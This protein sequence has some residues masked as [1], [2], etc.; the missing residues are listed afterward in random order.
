MAQNLMVMVNWS[1]LMK[2]EN[3]IKPFSFKSDLSLYKSYSF[4]MK[5]FNSII[6]IIHTFLT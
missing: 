4:V 2:D 6:N 3:V 1:T 5:E